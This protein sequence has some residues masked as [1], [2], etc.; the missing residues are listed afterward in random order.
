MNRAGSILCPAFSLLPVV[1]LRQYAVLCAVALGTAALVASTPA[2]AK[3][4]SQVFEEVSASVVVV[5]AYNAS[6]A[7]IGQGSGVIIAPGEVATNCHVL[8]DADR[9]QVR[10]GQE[11][12]PARVR[13][14][15][16]ERDLCQIAAAGLTARP[17]AIG[18]TKLLKVGIRVYTV[19][20][21]QGLDLTLGEGIVSALREVPGGRF[22]QTTAPISPGSSGGGLFDENGV[23]V[24]L[25]TFYVSEGQNLNFA[26]PV[27]WLR[28]LP[29]RHKA[30]TLEEDATVGWLAKALT[31]ESQKDWKGLL[32]HARQ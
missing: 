30:Q 31:L 15:D 29:T 32:A 25:T 14:S 5:E 10:H 2:M 9:L 18:A 24:G 21:P 13:L 27:E 1:I 4:P 17:A 16:A 28:E 6:G 8:K 26:L 23:L 11:Q 19:G 22:I 7:Q 20:A 12:H 3:T